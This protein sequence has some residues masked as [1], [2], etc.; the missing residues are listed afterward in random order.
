MTQNPTEIVAL[1]GATGAIGKSV[2][3][4]LHQKSQSYCAIGRSQATLEK[5][6]GRDSL[7]EITIW[8]PGQQSV[9]QE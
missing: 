7:A 8:N 2:V 4:A 3:A 6:F 5:E 1:I 9:R